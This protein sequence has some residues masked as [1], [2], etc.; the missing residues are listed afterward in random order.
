MYGS[1]IFLN[2]LPHRCNG[3][4]RSDAFSYELRTP[5]LCDID[6]IRAVDYFG[7]TVRPGMVCPLGKFQL[8]TDEQLDILRNGGGDDS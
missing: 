4:R 8:I 5:Q 3:L 7:G 1:E 6:T 2:R